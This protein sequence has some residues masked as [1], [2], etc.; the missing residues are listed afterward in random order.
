MDLG[1]TH[2]GSHPMHYH[3]YVLSTQHGFALDPDNPE[4][5]QHETLIEDMQSFFRQQD[6]KT[7][8][9]RSWM[10]EEEQ[11][12]DRSGQPILWQEMV[13]SLFLVKKILVFYITGSL[14]WISGNK[15][16]YGGCNL[17]GEAL[18]EG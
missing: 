18:K 6:V 12:L 3:T 2:I 16:K 11:V 8:R 7:L 9:E 15:D 1:Y 14:H 17:A 4:T 13:N 5:P 10:A